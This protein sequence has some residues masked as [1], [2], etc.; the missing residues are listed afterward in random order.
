M[1]TIPEEEQIST[2]I[3]RDIVT[4][5]D[6]IENFCPSG[7]RGFLLGSPAIQ[8]SKSLVAFIFFE[9]PG[10]GVDVVSYGERKGMDP[11]RVVDG[12]ELCIRDQYYFL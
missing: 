5:C 4:A 8:I 2:E 12:V 3:G 10:S 11:A 1:L 6:T 9:K 7:N